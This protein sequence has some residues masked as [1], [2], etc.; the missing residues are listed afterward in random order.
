[1]TDVDI[2]AARYQFIREQIKAAMKDSPYLVGIQLHPPGK[3]HW[4]ETIKDF[5]E[6]IDEAM[7]KE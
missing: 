4:F 2:D 5:D 3:K 6:A 1:M 7:G